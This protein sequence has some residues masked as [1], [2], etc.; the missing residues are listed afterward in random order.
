MVKQAMKSVKDDKVLR[1]VLDA[2]QLGLKYIANV[3]YGYTS[4]TFSGRMPAVEIADSIVQ[5]GRETLEKAIMLINST[6][7]WGGEVVYGDTDSVFVYLRGKSKEQAFRIGHDIA[8]T[9]TALNPSPIKLKFE[10]VFFPCVL[11]AKKRYVGFKYESIDDQIPVF[12]AKGIETVRRDGIPAQQKMV[13]VCLKMLFRWQDL[14]AIKEYCCQSW[15]KLLENRASVQ[16]FIFAKEIRMG[17]YSEAGPPPP[18]VVVAARRVIEDPMSEPQYGERVPYVIARGPPGSRLVDRAMDPLEMLNDSRFQLDAV[19]YISRVLIPPLERI[20]NLVGADIRSWFDE[21]PKP[22]HLNP[23]S[24]PAK[25]NKVVEIHR[26]NI[27][28]HFQSS[29]CLVCGDIASEGTILFLLDYA[30]SVIFP[31]LKK[32]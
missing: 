13:E 31:T 6:K 3:T 10:K 16:D 15:T 2:R 12:D 5:S 17:T 4:A 30:T 25:I 8:E 22:R 1:R 19:Y 26:L 18:G 9:V 23:T 7:K 32:P 14:S 29:Q 24:S 28:E 21:M 11:L 27:E 20:F